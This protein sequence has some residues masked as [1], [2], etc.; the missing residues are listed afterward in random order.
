MRI[1]GLDPGVATIGF[2]IVDSPTP[3]ELAL[4]SCGCIRTLGGTPFGDRLMEIRSDL[5]SLISRHRPDVA[6]MEALFF[7][8]N[9]RTA[10]IV[11][12]TRGVMLLGLAEAR[13]PVLEYN[14]L[15][16]KKAVVGYG[17]ATKAQVQK[18]VARILRLDTPPRP[19]DAADAVAVALCHRFSSRHRG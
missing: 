10:L 12:Q 18:M 19:D 13:I 8:K 15:A 9:V 4:V 11:G 5:A 1:L 14:P 3:T 7:N 6:A 17:R 16:V 2:G